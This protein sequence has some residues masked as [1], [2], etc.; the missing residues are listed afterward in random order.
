MIT[1]P[2]PHPSHPQDRLPT[3]A[4]QWLL[5]AGLLGGALALLYAL[6]ALTDSPRTNARPA[7]AKPAVTTHVQAPGAQVDARDRWIGEAG[8]KVAEHDQRLTRQDQ[9]NQEVLARFEGLQKQIEIARL[10]QTPQPGTSVVMPAPGPQPP[11]A[12]G[13]S[14]TLV[15]AYPPAAALPAL[16]PPLLPSQFAVATPRADGSGLPGGV[17]GVGALPSSRLIRITLEPAP[18][19]AS[20]TGPTGTAPPASPRSPARPPTVATYLP[21]SFTRAV[22]LGGLD[23]PTGGQAQTNPQPVLLRLADHA[24]LPNRFRGAVKECLVIGA[25]YGDISAERAYIRTENLSC[26]RHDGRTLEV[27]I[28]GSIFGEDGKV[29]VRGRL[30]SKQ[31]QIL[32]NA[33]TAGVVS[34]IGQAFQSRATTTALSPLGAVS[35]ITDGKEF[36]AG[37]STGVGRAMDRLAQYYIA[38]AEKTFPVIEVDAGRTVDVVLTQGVA[39]EAPTDAKDAD[40]AADDDPGDPTYPVSGDPLSTQHRTAGGDDDE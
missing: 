32:A 39:I 26:V 11:V 10:T 28:H 18:P 29:G 9:L 27:K 30:V 2:D 36:E 24:F 8:N 4:R 23:A 15:P 19:R 31:G 25:G 34:G 37:L 1:A 21:V 35:A 38:L 6:F 22:L 13:T 5:L 33:L 3:K 20:G 12:P 40:T 14:T 17:S 16:L 7:A